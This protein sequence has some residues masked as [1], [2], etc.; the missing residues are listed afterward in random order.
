MVVF[1]LFHEPGAG[2]GDI[3]YICGEDIVSTL[4]AKEP[5]ADQVLPPT[6]LSTLH[7]TTSTA[8]V[9]AYYFTSRIN[10]STTFRIALKPMSSSKHSEGYLPEARDKR[11][12]GVPQ[13]GIF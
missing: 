1:V 6:V 13:K 11:R 12:E 2:L 5:N 4:F 8:S 10:S 7:V 9:L 3:R